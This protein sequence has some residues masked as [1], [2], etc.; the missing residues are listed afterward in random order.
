MK[1]VQLKRHDFHVSKNLSK[2]NRNFQEISEKTFLVHH[3]ITFIIF[4]FTL[5]KYVI[6][7]CYQD[8]V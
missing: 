1:S 2:G 6:G 5:L 4:I 8:N 7:Q 3:Y